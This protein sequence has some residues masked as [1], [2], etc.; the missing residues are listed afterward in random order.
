MRKILFISALALTIIMSMVAGTFATYTKTVYVQGGTSTASAKIFDIT[1]DANVSKDIDVWL[2][3]N[4]AVDWHFDVR[5]YEQES[6]PTEVDMD[7]MLKIS[8]PTILEK[9]GVVTS[10]SL[11]GIDEATIKKVDGH[12]V[13]GANT[14][15]TYT[16]DRAFAANVAKELRGTLNF[17]WSNFSGSQEA[18]EEV[19]SEGGLLSVTITGNQAQ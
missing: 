17:N 12:E 5:N 2:A 18:T 15:F 6:A 14:V 1:A 13:D 8:I 4:E 9:H 10:L 7:L 19:A 11:E 16:V 3:P